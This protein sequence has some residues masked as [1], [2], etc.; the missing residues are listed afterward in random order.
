[1]CSTREGEK[2]SVAAFYALGRIFKN[3]K[4]EV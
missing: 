2:D 3:K 1:M 4:N